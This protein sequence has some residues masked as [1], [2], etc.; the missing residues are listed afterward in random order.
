MSCLVFP[1]KTSADFHRAFQSSLS[2]RDFAIIFR[3]VFL[4]KASADAHQA[5]LTSHC[6]FFQF[7]NASLT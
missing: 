2:L 6:Y 7:A 5:F 1:S 4:P 3:L